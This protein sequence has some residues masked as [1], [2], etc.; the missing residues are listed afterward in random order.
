MVDTGMHHLL[1][2]VLYNAY[3]EI[4]NLKQKEDTGKVYDIVGPICESADAL[5]KGRFFRGLK[6]DDLLAVLNVGAYGHSMASFYNSH[7]LSKEIL[8]P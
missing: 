1:R 8:I 5:R 3:H 2:L 7:P 6:Q 4:L